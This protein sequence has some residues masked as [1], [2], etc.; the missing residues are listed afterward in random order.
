MIVLEREGSFLFGKRADWK[1]IAPGYWCPISGHIEIDES[2]EDAVVREAMEEIGISVLP[3]RK[4][5]E[6]DTRDGK[7]RLH[8]WHARIESGEPRIANSEN[9]EIRWV[10]LD[11][12]DTLRPSF[13]EDL[14]IIR[15]LKAK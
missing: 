14:A 10:T 2:E 5:A 6:S 12:L 11:E 8:W 9:S 7:V 3:L 13:E 15:S 1:A 4:I